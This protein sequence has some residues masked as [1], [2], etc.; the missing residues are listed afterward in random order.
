MQSEK[1][2]QG[3][4]RMSRFPVETGK[5]TRFE[6]QAY[7]KPRDPKAIRDTHVA[8][9]GAPR[10]HPYDP[11]KIILVPDPYSTNTF[12]Y[13]FMTDDITYVE[14]LPSLVDMDGQTVTMARIWV[15]KMSVGMRCTPFFIED[16]RRF[17]M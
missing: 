17:A 4:I 15:K 8:F 9:S 7:K 16:I 13:E 12:Y 3:G 10:K 1:Q 5:S 11:Q 14:E 6:I 2:V